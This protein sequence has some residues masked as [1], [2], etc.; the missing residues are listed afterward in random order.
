MAGMMQDSVF[1][2]STFA[3]LS[4]GLYESDI[5]YGRIK[6]RGDFGLGTFESLDGEMVALGGEYFQV[7]FDGK[8]T[9]VK[10]A[11]TS[12]FATVKFFYPDLSFRVDERVNFQELKQLIDSRLPYPNL[13]YAIKIEGVFRFITARSV[14]KQEKPYKTLQV[15][16]KGQSV[17]YFDDIQGTLVG[18]RMPAYLDGF[19]IGGYH[20]HFISSDKNK[21]GHALDLTL[22][23]GT[24]YIDVADSVTAAF[25]RAIDKEMK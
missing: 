18:F 9:R 3:A 20:F 16:T 17:F 8:L 2:V 19:N 22:A 24:V 10:D 7:H 4:S 21:G 14:P 12:P 5:P 1:Q 25:P 15:V 11:Q 23:N 6:Q 13:I